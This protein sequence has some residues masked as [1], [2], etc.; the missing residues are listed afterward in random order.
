MNPAFI[1]TIDVEADDEWSTSTGL[2]TK[3]AAYLPRFHELCQRYGLRPTYLVEWSMAQSPVLREF[4]QAVIAD[5]SAEIGMHL[6]AWTA[7]PYLPLTEEDHRHKPFLIDF[8]AA[9]MAEKVKVM[10][11]TL[12]EAFQVA[13]TSHRAGRWMLD[14]NYARILVEH[15]YLVD[16]SVTPRIS[17]AGTTGHPAG[18][19]PRDYSRFPA[20]P[21]FVDLDD[22]G[23]PGASPLLEVPMT[24]VPRSRAALWSRAADLA[25]STSL[26]G[27]VVNRFSPAVTW[28]RPNGRNRR[29]LLDLARTALAEGWQHVEFMIHSSELMP[30]GSPYFRTRR[31]VEGLFDDIDALFAFVSTGFDPVTLTEFRMTFPVRPGIS[32]P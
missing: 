2:T 13:I 4:G 9:A 30:G 32:R 5:K 26:A 3:N 6:H 14:E 11:G 8:P 15:G 22:I 31:S 27:R 28:M 25:G 18:R 7:P 21:Y 19:G 12:E 20:Q 17:W 24:I 23:R 1:I 16:C 29:R 10:T